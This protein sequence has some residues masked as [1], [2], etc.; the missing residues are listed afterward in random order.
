V[1]HHDRKLAR[2]APVHAAVHVRFGEAA[3]AGRRAGARLEDPQI[4][5][6]KIDLLDAQPC[7]RRLVDRDERVVLAFFERSGRRLELCLG[8]EGTVP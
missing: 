6:L 8:S 2:G 7:A 3:R 5:S 1:V 4:R